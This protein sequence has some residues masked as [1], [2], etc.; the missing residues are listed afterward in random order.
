MDW[1]TASAAFELAPRPDGTEL[2]SLKLALLLLD[3]LHYGGFKGEN[4]WFGLWR[5]ASTLEGF[6]A[7]GQQ[8]QY[9]LHKDAIEHY[10]NAGVTGPVV[11]YF[12]FMFRDAD[13]EAPTWGV[14]D[15]AWTPKKAYRAYVESNH[16]V[17]V[18][19]PQA[20]RSPVKLPGDPWFATAADDRSRFTDAPWAGAEMIVANDTLETL[21]GAQ[22]S[23]W[24]EDAAGARVAA[25][26]VATGQST[27]WPQS[28]WTSADAGTGPTVPDDL[29]GGTYFLRAQIADAAGRVRSTNSYEIVVPDPT[30]A[31]L[32]S[33]RPARSRPCSTARPPPRA[34][35]TGMAAPS[36]T[37]PVLGCAA[38]WPAGARSRRRGIDLYEAVQGEHLF[39]HIV[40]ELAG[41]AGAEHVTDAAWTIR[42]EV[43]SPEVKTRTLLRYV[44]LVVRRAETLLATRGRRPARRRPLVGAPAPD[45]LP[46]SSLFPAVG[47]DV[48]PA[49]IR[50]RTAPRRSHEE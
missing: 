27:C 24:V 45:G 16:P 47:R 15:A 1:P 25:V 17:R 21:S 29:P 50:P 8:R 41:L 38:C 20:L 43:V 37:A 22:V 5:P 35:T 49:R 46:Q 31:W 48:P 32:D 34:S 36:C 23:V 7:S 11:G 14:V 2:L 6:V 18:A 28:G 12:S 4:F 10:L 26:D 42:S 33:L 44:E 40:P 9:R 39:R 3:V 19:L 30:F 13:W